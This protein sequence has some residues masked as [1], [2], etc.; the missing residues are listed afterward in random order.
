MGF[1]D[2]IIVFVSAVFFTALLVFVLAYKEEN[3]KI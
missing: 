1:W 2:L 3:E